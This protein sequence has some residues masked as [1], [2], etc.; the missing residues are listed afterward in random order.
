MTKY[1]A[2]YDVDKD[3]WTIKPQRNRR[4][5]FPGYDHS[6]SFIGFYYFTVEAENHVGALVKAEVEFTLHKRGGRIT[7]SPDE[8][9]YKDLG[10]L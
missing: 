3:E 7:K 5:I 1:L 9:W 8:L 10:Q 4:D 2:L 6:F